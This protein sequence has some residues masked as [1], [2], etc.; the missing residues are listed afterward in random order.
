MPQHGTRGQ[1]YQQFLQNGAL[2]LQNQQAFENNNN[3]VPQHI[4][5]DRWCYANSVQ[6]QMIHVAGGV[7]Q[8]SGGNVNGSGQV[9]HNGAFQHQA[10]N[11]HINMKDSEDA[12][13]QGQGQG[14]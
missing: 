12:A 6:T 11:Y 10:R 1:E 13:D 8:V 2:A 5:P 7:T 14:L 9:F 3:S 4:P